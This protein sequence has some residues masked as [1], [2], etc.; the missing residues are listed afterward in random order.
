MP[1]PGSSIVHPFLLGSLDG[2]FPQRVTIQTKGHGKD[3]LGEETDVWEN[4]AGHVDLPCRKAPSTAGSTGRETRVEAG[5]YSTATHVVVV[6][7]YLPAVTP[8]M[9]A[10]VG[11]V[12]HDIEAVDLDAEN[13]TTRLATRIVR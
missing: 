7:T 3:D 1:R 9:R 8:R 12:D 6:A 10:V 13:E 2:F 4:L 5:V 11:G